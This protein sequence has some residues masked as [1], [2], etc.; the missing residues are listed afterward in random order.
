MAG[1]YHYRR[2]QVPGDERF[3][4]VPDKNMHSHVADSLQYCLMGA[5]EGSIVVRRDPSTRL[6]RPG[7]AVSDYKME[8]WM[9]PGTS[10]VAGPYMGDDLTTVLNYPNYFI[11]PE[12]SSSGRPAPRRRRS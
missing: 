7:F 4:D 3:H 8:W 6:K 12:D 1:G 9:V 11:R 5:G 10:V 2:V